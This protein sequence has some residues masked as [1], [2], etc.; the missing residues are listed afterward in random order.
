MG[1][2]IVVAIRLVRGQ[3]CSAYSDH[4]GPSDPLNLWWWTAAIAFGGA[5]GD[6]ILGQVKGVLVK[7]ERV[8]GEWIAL[9]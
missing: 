6:V 8:L 4:L 7:L 2:S 1:A 3:F 9:V 5:G